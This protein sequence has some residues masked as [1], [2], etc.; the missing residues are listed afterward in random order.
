VVSGDDFLYSGL[1]GDGS[2]E[3]QVGLSRQGRIRHTVVGGQRK[4]TTSSYSTFFKRKNRN[5]RDSK[6]K[7]SKILSADRK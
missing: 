4:Y 1:C 3:K 5:S 6:R 7:P 2:T